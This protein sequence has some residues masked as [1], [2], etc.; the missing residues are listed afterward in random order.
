M[1]A[2]SAAIRVV[3]VLATAVRVVAAL[4]AAVILLHAVFVF[5]EANPANPLVELSTRVRDTFAWFTR[6]LFRTDDPKVGEAIND[7][8]AAGIYVVVGSLLSRLIVRFAP[9]AKAKA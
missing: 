1:A 3:S 8:I 5:F 2:R 6:N 4:I 7:A 9:S